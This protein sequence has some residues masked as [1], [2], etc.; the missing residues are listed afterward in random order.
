MIP[1]I[2]PLDITNKRIAQ[3]IL[4]I[5]IPA[6]QLEADLIGFQGIPA[7]SETVE[8]LLNSTETFIGFFEDHH[9]LGVLS[10]EE[11]EKLVDICRLVVAPASFRKGVGRQLVEYV[12]NEIRLSRDVVVST[13]Q[14]NT[15][16]VTLYKKLGFVEE[17]LFEI[18]TG[19]CLVNLRYYH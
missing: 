6:Y 5:Q 15:P 19:V 14:K 18:A 9:L 13:G 16:A 4:S 1:I 8:D 3:S 12:T 11:N 10:Y 17:D 7:L 2:K